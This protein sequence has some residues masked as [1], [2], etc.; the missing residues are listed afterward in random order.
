MIRVPSSC[1]LKI[2]D[3]ATAKRIIEVHCRNW[4]QMKFQ[5]ACCYA[6]DELLDDE[7]MFDK[8]RRRAFKWVRESERVRLDSGIPFSIGNRSIPMWIPSYGILWISEFLRG[9]GDWILFM[10]IEKREFYRPK[11][12]RGLNSHPGIGTIG[13]HSYH[14]GCWINQIIGKGWTLTPCTISGWGSWRIA[15]NGHAC[16]GL[17]GWLWI[18]GSCWCS[19]SRST[20][21]SWSSCNDSGS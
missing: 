10:V 8:N 7:R 13:F 5:L 12:A 18:N 11:W 15:R 20:T 17:I 6:I 16:T 9:S 4:A 1:R 21:A 3:L 2:D 14:C 19:G